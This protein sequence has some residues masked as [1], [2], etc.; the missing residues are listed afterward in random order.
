MQT[1]V[2]WAA[3]VSLPPLVIGIA[4]EYLILSRKGFSRPGPA[5]PKAED[6]RKAAGPRPMTGAD[7]P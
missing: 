6:A 4:W 7:L 3:A 1:L 2:I 5:N